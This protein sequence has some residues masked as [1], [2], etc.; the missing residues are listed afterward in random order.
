MSESTLHVQDPLHAANPAKSA[1]V[2]ASAGVGKTYLLVTRLLR[3]LM[4]DVR[5][6]SILAITFTR[7]A[8]AEM[9]SRLYERLYVLAVD[10]DAEVAK[11]LQAIDIK[12]S[13]QNIKKARGLY[14]NLL[15]SEYQIKTST[16]HAFCQEVLRKFPLEANVPPGFEL[17]DDEASA[18]L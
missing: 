11:A 18:A 6:D 7:K 16:F 12:P 13:P 17:L 9:Q 2:K 4:H 10:V 15:R 1:I 3:L 5:P 8:A 14:E